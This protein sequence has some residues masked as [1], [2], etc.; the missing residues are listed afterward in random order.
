MP[1]PAARESASPEATRSTPRLLVP[2][3]LPAGTPGPELTVDGDRA[4]VVVP[5]EGSTGGMIHYS[6]AR[7]RGL[8]V[9]LPH[10]R[11]GL[12][13]GVHAVRR[14]GFR[15]VW[16]RELPEGGLQVRFTFTRPT[17]DERVLDVEDQGIKV[18][19][20]LPTATRQAHR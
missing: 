13:V 6:L 19:V 4:T 16:V 17:P 3:P 9:N 5:V 2:R 15:F 10:A 18:R 20:A 11:P 7:P 12:P 8:V 1:A 14:D